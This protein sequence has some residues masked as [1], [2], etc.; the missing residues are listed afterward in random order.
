VVK[1]VQNGSLIEQG[2]SSKIV[3]ARLSGEYLLAGNISLHW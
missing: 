2:S 1:T 3:A